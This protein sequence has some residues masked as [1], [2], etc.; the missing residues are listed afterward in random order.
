MMRLLPIVEG[1]GEV[2][3][4][5]ILLRRLSY[6]AEQYQ[7]TVL[8]GIRA[9]KT[10]LITR[11]GL[12]KVLQAAR[13]I[14]CDAILI[15]I[16]ADGDCPKDL[17]SQLLNFAAEIAGD[18]P[19]EVV[20]AQQEYEAWFLASIEALRGHRDMRPDAISRDDPENPRGAKAHL[21][22][23][24]VGGRRYVETKHQAA[25]SELISLSGAYAKC[26]SF[27]KLTRAFGVLHEKMGEAISEW[28]PPE[29][30]VDA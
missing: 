26:R 30:Q 8:S 4:A 29:W 25:F 11:E 5:P 16:D 21:Q 1:H 23:R 12:D 18:I 19:L 9:N 17:A 24:M 7:L 3:A 2:A 22:Q 14:G 28:P 20:I 6:E 13:R 15:L 27:R 10:Q